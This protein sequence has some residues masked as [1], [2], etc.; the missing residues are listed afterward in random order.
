MIVHLKQLTWNTQP[1]TRPRDLDHILQHNIGHFLV[2]AA[3]CRLVADSIDT[4]IYHAAVLLDDSLHDVHLREVDW[5]TPNL[6]ARRKPFRHAINNKALARAPQLRRVSR[7]QPD[8]PTSKDGNTLAWL[9]PAERHTVP[10]GR[11]DVGQQDEVL[12]VLGAGWQLQSVEVGIRDA[13]VLCL[14]TSVRAH[15]NVA[16]GTASKAWVN[17]CAEG[18][19]AF[20]AVAAAAVGDVEWP[21]NR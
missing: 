3:R 18:C 17:T 21:T 1:S 11:E 12:L 2:G 7:H 8:W 9:E 4:A 20:F 14:A 6:L 13:N 15:G 19:L 10:A 5:Y 16:V